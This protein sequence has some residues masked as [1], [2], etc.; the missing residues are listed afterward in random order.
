MMCMMSAVTFAQYYVFV[1]GD[2]V[3]L[4]LGPNES[5]KLTSNTYPRLCTGET[6]PYYGTDG[7]YYR[8]GVIQHTKK[9]VG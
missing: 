6:Y 9:M 2:D 5:T 4:R 7:N 8:I 3:C 1:A